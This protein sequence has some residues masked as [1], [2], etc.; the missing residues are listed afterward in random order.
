MKPR[1]R[2]PTKV[3]DIKSEDSYV[4]KIEDERMHV[5]ANLLPPYNV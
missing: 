3:V 5:H 1:W 4:V 2:V